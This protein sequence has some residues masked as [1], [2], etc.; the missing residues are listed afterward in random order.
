VTGKRIRSDSALEL[1]Q[2]F[3]IDSNCQPFLASTEKKALIKTAAKTYE[4]QTT[5]I[6][7]DGQRNDETAPVV[8]PDGDLLF[9]NLSPVTETNDFT[10]LPSA[11]YIYVPKLGVMNAVYKP[12]QDLEIQEFGT[13]L[14]LQG[15]NINVDLQGKPVFT[16]FLGADKAKNLTLNGTLPLDAKNWTVPQALWSNLH[17]GTVQD[18][19]SPATSE[20]PADYF[21][22]NNSLLLVTNTEPSYDH[23][24]A[25]WSIA[26][27]SAAET[28]SGMQTLSL[29]EASGMIDDD[30]SSAADLASN[31]TIQTKLPEIQ[32]VA[33]EISASA[34][35]D[36]RRQIELIL[37][38]LKAHYS[39][40]YSMVD[41]NIVR[42]LSTE[43][44]L[45]RG[46]GVCQ[47]YSVIYTAIARALQIPPRIVM[48]YHL[49]QKAGAHAWVESELS[50]GQWRVIEPQDP[51]SLTAM[52]T[53]HY[54]PTLR[55]TLLENKSQ[56]L[57]DAFRVLTGLKL[58]FK[59]SPK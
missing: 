14:K 29:T 34:P 50:P 9:Y 56:N 23:F 28:Q 30:R 41:N 3:N 24:K 11:A 33:S 40:D 7:S 39:Y 35:N 54:F 22:V 59:P 38:Y 45:A 12:T 57:A 19:D 52:Q 1:N 21:T 27:R 32:K 51:D 15:G 17:L 53:R 43:E 5:T 49:D 8:L 16:L 13:S 20:L 31:D 48:G 18:L 46:N 44:A 42:P 25:Y 2:T 26:S 4:D 6:N 10:N 36:R 37:A 55:A 47:H 58:T